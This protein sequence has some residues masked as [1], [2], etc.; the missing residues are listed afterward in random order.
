[1]RGREKAGGCCGNGMSLAQQLRTEL[2]SPTRLNDAYFA[3]LTACP[4]PGSVCDGVARAWEVV[5]L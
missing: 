1:M 2:L 3:L 4:T 5:A